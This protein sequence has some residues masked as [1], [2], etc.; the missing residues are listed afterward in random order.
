MLIL[1]ILLIDLMLLFVAVNIQ[2]WLKYHYVPYFQLLLYIL[3]TTWILTYI[4][5]IDQGFFE[6]RDIVGR[7]RHIFRK[8]FVFI[9]LSSIIIIL[10]NLDEI[11]RAMFLGS[12]LIFLIFQYPASYFYTYLISTRE[13]SP[14]NNRILIVGANKIGVAL[15]KYYKF[16][17]TAGQVIG[18]LDNAPSLKK[19]RNILGAFDDFQ[20]V[21]DERPFNEVIITLPLQKEDEIRKLVNLAEYNGVRP[22]VVANYYSLFQRNFEF[23]NLAGI[24]TVNIR[25]FPMDSYISRFWKRVFDVIFSFIALLITFPILLLVAIA[26]K[27]DSKGPVF[28][29]PVRLGKRGTEIRIYKFRSM[30]HNQTAADRT[31]STALNDDRITRVGKIIR[32]YSL[33]ELPQ[34][35]NVLIGDMSV[36]GP[37]PH[38]LDLNKRFQQTTQNYLVRH[39]VKP[40][41]TGWAQVNGWRGPTETK[42]QYIGRTLHDLWYIEHWN[43]AL[44]LYIIFLTIF[45]KG[46]RNNA[47]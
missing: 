13:D 15:E 24:P 11:S 39:Y 47:F 32:K 10:F 9:L 41:I 22:S 4:F 40:G 1:V 8:F 44:D 20:K 25:E 17:P 31:K 3:L 12:S 27:L 30:K 5:F 19:D 45:G 35:I 29:R 2:A 16:S 33:D 43:F 36:V 23:K 38:R 18:F 37:R 21:F 26:I 7:I 34:F 46:T 28:Y 6:I 14:S 42:Y